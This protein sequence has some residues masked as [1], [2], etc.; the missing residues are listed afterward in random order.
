M[1]WRKI[2]TIGDACM[3]AAGLPEE[4]A[5]PRRGVAETALEMGCEAERCAGEGKAR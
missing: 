2:K 1:A 5:R 3:V 4:R